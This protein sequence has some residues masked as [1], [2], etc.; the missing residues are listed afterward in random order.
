MVSALRCLL[1]AFCSFL[2]FTMLVTTV[3][4]LNSAE[5]LKLV[6]IYITRHA[7]SKTTDAFSE[8]PIEINTGDSVRWVNRDGAYHWLVS[9]DISNNINYEVFDSGLLESHEKFTKKF[10]NIAG[11]IPYH[12]ILH[13]NMIGDVKVNSQTIMVNT[14]QSS[15]VTR[16]TITIFG[17]VGTVAGPT[18]TVRIQVFDPEGN[19]DKSHKVLPDENG[20]FAYSF[21]AGRLLMDT[22]GTYKVKV[23]YDGETARTSF[24]FDAS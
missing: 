21:K 19:T 15:Y 12:C 3:A 16:N 20:F 7:S 23:T 4:S 9:G 18:H 8:Y 14:A 24:S 13:P 1:T 5:A 11:D 17:D 2:I 22:D 10:N 6:V